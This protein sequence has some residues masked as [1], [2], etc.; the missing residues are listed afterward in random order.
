MYSYYVF[1]KHETITAFIDQNIRSFICSV[2]NVCAIKII[3]DD[4]LRDGESNV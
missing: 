4:V 2:Y 1:N 3:I